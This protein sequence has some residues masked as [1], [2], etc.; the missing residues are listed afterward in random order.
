MARMPTDPLFATQW[1]FLNGTTPGVDLNILPAWGD[2]TGAGVVVA[3]NDTGVELAHPDLAANIATDLSYDFYL[4]QWGVND[5]DAENAHGTMVAGCVGAVADNGLGGVGAAHGATMAGFRAGQGDAVQYGA[6]GMV[7]AREIGADIVNNSWGNTYL[8]GAS[9][10]EAWTAYAEQGRDGLGGVTFVA[11]GNARAKSMWSNYDSDN[12]NP[13]VIDVAAISDSG[14]FAY[15]SSPGPDLLVSAPGEKVVTTA[16]GETY[17]TTSGTS[18]ASPLTA[19]VGALVLEA[20]PALAIGDVIDILAYSARQQDPMTSWMGDE[21]AAR[22]LAWKQLSQMKPAVAALLDFTVPATAAA[23]P[24]RSV[25]AVRTDWDW[26]ANAADDWNGG[27]LTFNPDY[28]YGLVDALGAVRLAESWGTGDKTVANMVDLIQVDSTASALIGTGETVTVTRE[29]TV[30]EAMTVQ[31]AEVALDLPHAQADGLTITLTA[32]S[33]T[34][35]ILFDDYSTELDLAGATAAI[36]REILTHRA[37][38]AT[39]GLDD[40]IELGTRQM[41][42]ESATGTWTVT[43]TYE[44][45]HDTYGDTS[46]EEVGFRL[47]GDRDDGDD[48]YVYSSEFATHAGDAGRTVLTDSNGG[49]DQINAAMIGSASTV[50]LNGG[51]TSTLAGTGLT[52]AEGTVIENA[53]TGDGNDRLTGNDVANELHGGRGFDTLS[54]GAGD[55]TLAGDRNDDL[56]TG[57]DG[58]DTFLFTAS[59]GTDT[60]TDFTDGTD[61]VRIAATTGNTAFDDL[62]LAQ[63]GADAV[64]TLADGG[65]VILSGIDVASLDAGDFVF[66]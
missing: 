61:A 11:G 62:S 9:D 54:G 31:G 34:T 19:G 56:L 50:D 24:L 30:T 53:W 57:G 52:I 15:F 59:A 1:Q 26:A 12:S 45:L 32:P 29:F 63:A 35:S 60:V 16:V 46:L 4:D 39:F 51:A 6:A 58:A 8:I 3:I 37:A 14:R 55:D 44:N 23:V 64:V 42:G 17:T 38:G 5:L 20:N 10:T 41:L 28:G 2:Y 18:F 48:R 66:G 47:V 22:A 65:R 13:Y 33:G 43:V 27:G 7:L 25:E 36:A 49:T 21:T 40:T